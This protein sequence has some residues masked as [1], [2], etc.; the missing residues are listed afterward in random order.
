MSLDGP[1]AIG[2]AST[3]VATVMAYRLVWVS[4]PHSCGLVSIS[5]LQKEFGATVGVQETLATYEMHLAETKQFWFN[6]RFLAPSRNC[7]EE[8][9]VD[10]PNLAIVLTYGFISLIAEK[11]V[12]CAVYG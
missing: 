12:P 2:V 11:I 10:Q 7:I 9:S 8:R 1:I 5:R 4:D 3:L 6:G